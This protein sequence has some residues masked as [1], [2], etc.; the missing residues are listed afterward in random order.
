MQDKDRKDALDERMFQVLREIDNFFNIS[1]DS[2]RLRRYDINVIGSGNLARP[3]VYALA[4]DLL[5]PYG[6][7]DTITWWTRDHHTMFGTKSGDELRE[8]LYQRFNCRE[9]HKPYADTKKI[10]DIRKRI[11]IRPYTSLTDLF[12]DNDSIIARSKSKDPQT[13]GDLVV[14]LNRYDA[15]GPLFNN[16]DGNHVPKTRQEVEQ[17]LSKDN[18]GLLAGVDDKEKW[19]K[20]LSNENIWLNANTLFYREK[21]DYEGCVQTLLQNQD[22]IKAIIDVVEGYCKDNEGMYR[23]KNS[24]VNSLI[25]NA[26]LAK[27][28]KGYEGTVI[29]M[30]NP[31]EIVN[32]QFA[33][34]SG[35]PMN[36]IFAPT[37]NDYARLKVILKDVYYDAFGKE[38][39]GEMSVPPVIGPHDPRMIIER[40]KIFYDDK[41]FDELFEH[42]LPDKIFGY[43]MQKFRTY[44][45]IHMDRYNRPAED[46]VLNSLLPAVKIMLYEKNEEWMRGCIFNHKEKI[47]TGGQFTLRRGHVVPDFSHI[48]TLKDP[49]KK[50]F[51]TAITS[52]KELIERLSS[53]DGTFGPYFSEYA[54]IPSL[55]E[56]DAIDKETLMQGIVA[57]TIDAMFKPDGKLA[58]LDFSM[59]FRSSSSENRHAVNKYKFYGSINPEFTGYHYIMPGVKASEMDRE[60]RNAQL[61]SFDAQ[62]DRLVILAQRVH[63]QDPNDY[64]LS[65]YHPK[66]SDIHHKVNLSIGESIEQMVLNGHAYMLVNR[67]DGKHLY[68]FDDKM[69]DLGRIPVK[70]F[71]AILPFGNSVAGF[72]KNEVYHYDD[73]W[74]MLSHTDDSIDTI[75]NIDPV[76]NILYYMVE[77]RLIGLKTFVARDILSNESAKFDAYRHGFSAYSDKDGI[78]LW[79]IGDK[80][81]ACLE[82]NSKK[83]LLKNHEDM[84][85]C[86]GSIPVKDG[87]IWTVKRDIAALDNGQ[88]LDQYGIIHSDNRQFSLLVR[89]NRHILPIEIKELRQYQPAGGVLT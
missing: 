18:I 62:G 13:Q 6:V 17:Y 33:T 74:K 84:H 26:A 75:V 76:N 89:T 45:T 5:H 59:Y 21:G 22:M 27:A 30:A 71:T 35:I 19:K 53:I 61:N 31:V 52:D 82:Y 88:Y 10:L 49:L 80:G 72:F 63:S 40:D 48:D 65:E 78:Q 77:D 64:Y 60:L 36:R 79:T 42:Q 4:D 39:E 41:S 73:G 25:G 34:H 28:L 24:L 57:N 43:V 7:I 69:H 37:E 44:G 55:P 47:F 12:T 3:F 58:D 32:H 66:K 14:I 67:S 29:N 23:T 85:T 54:Q 16:I 70:N 81:I 83:D 8:N 38:F 50:E 56:T 68:L 15:I 46:T 2:S 9:R 11:I 1:Y 51:I 86:L 87:Q 20:I